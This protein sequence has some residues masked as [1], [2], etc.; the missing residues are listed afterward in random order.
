VILGGKGR[1]ERPSPHTSM[2]SIAFVS[3]SGSQIIFHVKINLSVLQKCVK[4]ASE[5]GAGLHLSHRQLLRT[6]FWG[7][8][9]GDSSP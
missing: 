5:Y 7:L 2:I 1:Q 6:F 4:I 8:L 3:T 9:T